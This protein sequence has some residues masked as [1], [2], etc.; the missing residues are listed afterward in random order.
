MQEVVSSSPIVMHIFQILLYQHKLVHTSMYW[1][2]LVHTCM[3][4]YILVC[5]C[6]YYFP[7][8]GTM[9]WYMAVRDSGHVDVLSPPSLVPINPLS[10]R[11]IPAWIYLS[12]FVHLF[13]FL[14]ES[15][16]IHLCYCTYTDILVCTVAQ[17]NT[18]RYITIL[19]ESETDGRNQTSRFMPIYVCMKR[20]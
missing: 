3:Y 18:S 6:T 17:A 12:G 5:T 14:R 11:H 20:D 7:W 1:S 2:I 13:G 15:W 9:L 8:F 10:Y 16:C 19:L 4:L